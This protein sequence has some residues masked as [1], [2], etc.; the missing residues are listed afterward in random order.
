[1]ANE[2]CKYQVVDKANSNWRDGV[3]HRNCRLEAI[4]EGYCN[5]HHPVHIATALEQT[6]QREIIESV[7]E[8]Q[9]KEE[10]IVGAF[11]RLRKKTN[12][13]EIL[14][15]VSNAKDLAESIWKIT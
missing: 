12:F 15:E 6:A 14:L 4:K 3:K 8:L 7:R 5:L 1:M 2:S 13:D 9:R 11:M 10:L